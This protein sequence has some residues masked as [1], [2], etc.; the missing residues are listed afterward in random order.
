MTMKTDYNAWR[1]GFD[2]F[3]LVITGA[4]AAWVWVNNR[5]KATETDVKNVKEC[6]DNDVKGIERSVNR[7]A[8]RVTALENRIITKEDLGAVYDRVNGVA[9]QVSEMNG[10]LDGVIKQG[11]II[12]EYLLTKGDKA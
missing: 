9:G 4:V 11:E 1:L 7:V 2:I 12:Q 3:Q 8:N 10:K 6:V 5:A